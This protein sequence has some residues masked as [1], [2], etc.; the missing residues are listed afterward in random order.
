MSRRDPEARDRVVVGT[1]EHSDLGTGGWTLVDAQGSR[2]SLAGV[3][4]AELAGRRVRAEGTERA[5]YG[6]SMSG[7]VLEL[8]SIRAA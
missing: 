1:L 3:V 2:W 7:P 6:F 8:R 5:L 4:P